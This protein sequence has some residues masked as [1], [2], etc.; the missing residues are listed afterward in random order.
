[1]TVIHTPKSGKDLPATGPDVAQPSIGP[2]PAEVLFPEA[3]RRERHR[4]LVVLATTLLL[5]AVGLSSYFAAGLGGGPPSSTSRPASRADA[6]R[7]NVGLNSGNLSWSCSH[8]GPAPRVPLAAPP[9]A[10]V[11]VKQRLCFGP[12][13][14]KA[15]RGGNPAQL[16]LSI[17]TRDGRTLT[18]VVMAFDD[19]SDVHLF[20]AYGP[21]SLWIYS[22]STT[23]GP[24]LLRFSDKTGTLLQSVRMP[25]VTAP[26]GY[27]N[28]EGVWIANGQSGTSPRTD[29]FHVSPGSAKVIV[30][31]SQPPPTLPH[32]DMTSACVARS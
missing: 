2:E 9:R 14:P 10:D 32:C 18:S 8:S 30:L 7:T 19:L 5:V 6:S 31:R 25:A 12:G 16:R 17:P 29:V 22:A 27:A 23:S 4:R 26:Y 3:K 13:M 15:F 21:S 28:A 20:I 1:M 24:L 11:E